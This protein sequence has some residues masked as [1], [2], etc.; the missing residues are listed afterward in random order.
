MTGGMWAGRLGILIAVIIVA[1]AS[2]ALAFFLVVIA[3]VGA[4]FFF[5]Y[6]GSYLPRFVMDVL[7]RLTNKS[8]LV[9]AHEKQQE[10]L[11]TINAAEL[12]AKLK[13]KVIGQD[14]VID[15]I[16]AQLRRRVAAKRKDKP[17]AV[18][19]F[20]GAPGVGKS[21]LAKALAEALYGDKTHLLFVEMATCDKSEASWSLFGSP[22]GYVG[23]PGTL[24]SG[25]RDVPDSVVLLDEFEKAHPDVHKRFLSA[26]NDGFLTDLKSGEKIPTNEAIFILTTNA[27]CKRIGELARD[28]TGSLD[29]LDRMVKSTLADVHFVPEVLSRIDEVFAFREMQGLDIARVVALLIED[30]TQQL[31]L[32]IAEGGIDATILLDAIEKITKVGMEGGV[33]VIRRQI[34][35]QITDGLIDAKADG[36]KKVR[37]EAEGD[38]VRVIPVFDEPPQEAGAA[39]ATAPPAAATR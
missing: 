36:A 12:A 35:K 31:G 29:E 30:E 4:I 13:A 11:T 25:L 28:H 39:E 14:A 37:L 32:E 10:K 9:K 2:A 27:A 23:G 15:Q 8:A 16:A 6:K 5:L 24:T 7:D 17:L 20:A 34:E 1:Q 19:C 21:H 18:F 33:R 22:Q 38:R 26:W 3:F